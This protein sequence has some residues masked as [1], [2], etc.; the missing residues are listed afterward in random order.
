MHH[1]VIRHVAVAVLGQLLER[2]EASVPAVTVRRAKENAPAFGYGR[3]C[4]HSRK[5]VSTDKAQCTA[6]F[7][8]IE[9]KISGEL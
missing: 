5:H 2:H 7:G 6:L 8:K 4:R 9:G 3:E 1:L